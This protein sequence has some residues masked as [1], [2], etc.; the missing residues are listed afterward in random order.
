MTLVDHN[1]FFS[2]IGVNLE[3]YKIGK[4]KKDKYFF[5]VERNKKNTHYL[6]DN[7]MFCKKY[8]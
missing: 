4:Q 1:F 2:G 5:Y 3:Y 7:W 6:N 8:H